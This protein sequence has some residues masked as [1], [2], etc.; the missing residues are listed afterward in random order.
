MTWKSSLHGLLPYR[1]SLENDPELYN[2]YLV[3]LLE[4]IFGLG[5]KLEG[6]TR[7]TVGCR[8]T[9]LLGSLLKLSLFIIVSQSK[10]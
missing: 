5:L 4:F 1:G 8:S 10:Y 3:N 2:T 9:K 6:C 7:P